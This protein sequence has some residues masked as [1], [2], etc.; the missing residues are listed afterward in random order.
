MTSR[1]FQNGRGSESASKAELYVRTPEN[2]AHS[3]SRLSNVS[4]LLI[5]H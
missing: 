3:L 5:A 4:G 2:A 1:Y